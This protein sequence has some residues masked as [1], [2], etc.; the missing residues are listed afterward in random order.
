MVQLR[1][2][3]EFDKQ[4]SRRCN[5]MTILWNFFRIFAHWLDNVENINSE[6]VV[7]RCWTWSLCFFRGSQQCFDL[8]L[9]LQWKQ[10]TGENVVMQGELRTSAQNHNRQYLK[11]EESDNRRRQRS[12]KIVDRWTMKSISECWYTS[13]YQATKNRWESKARTYVLAVCNLGCTK[14]SRDV[15]LVEKT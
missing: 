1:C 12:L 11:E 9:V 6:N 7:G 4:T 8:K 10:E 14:Q 13:C 2:S 15:P 5:S 3:T